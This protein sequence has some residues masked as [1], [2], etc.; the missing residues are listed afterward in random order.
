MKVYKL[1]FTTVITSMLI[2]CG[3]GIDEFDDN[4]VGESEADENIV[5]SAQR[6]VGI[7]L[8]TDNVPVMDASVTLLQTGET[9]RTDENGEFIFENATILSGSLDIAI[10]SVFGSIQTGLSEVPDGASEITIELAIEPE[11]LFVSVQSLNFFVDNQVVDDTPT[12]PDN[13]TEDPPPTPTP[14]GSVNSGPFDENGNTSRFGIPDGRVGNISRGR[15]AFGRTCADHHPQ[16]QGRGL[17]FPQ[18]RAVSSLPQHTNVDFD[19]VDLTA[20]IN[21]HRR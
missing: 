20:Y 13:N 10:Q 14:E 1:L 17:N 2:G 7:L 12:E 16:S 3:A 8:S 15:I 9:S 21:R 6:V 11:P 5:A 4:F 19:L 18:L